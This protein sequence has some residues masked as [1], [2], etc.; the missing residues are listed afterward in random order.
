MSDTNLRDALVDVR[1]AYRLLYGF[2]RRLF[3]MAR[4]IDKA[5]DDWKFKQVD[6]GDEV[7]GKKWKPVKKGTNYWQTLPFYMSSFV[8]TK[9]ALEDRLLPS[10]RI[11]GLMVQVDSAWGA[12]EE[13]DYEANPESFEM[14]AEAS[15][16]TAAFYLARPVKEIPE[17][18]V[19]DAWDE[20]DGGGSMEKLTTEDGAIFYTLWEVDLGELDTKEALIAK[21]AWFTEQAEAVVA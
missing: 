19:M 6:P 15:Q 1:K 16:T 7:L 5:L 14:S 18:S 20:M 4:E 8:W 12:G 2:N 3:D 11:F 17:A 9:A 13:G 10:D 21:L